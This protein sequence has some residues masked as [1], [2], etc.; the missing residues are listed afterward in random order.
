MVRWL[1]YLSWLVLILGVSF[2]FA[3][4][5]LYNAW[6]DVGV[7]SISITLIIFGFLGILLAREHQ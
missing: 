2:Y 1:W 5:F 7:Y 6:T 3:W 4:S